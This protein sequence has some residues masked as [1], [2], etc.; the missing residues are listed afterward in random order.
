VTA[1]SVTGL[2]EIARRYRH[3]NGTEVDV[4]LVDA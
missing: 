4:E 1:L 2:I 3:R